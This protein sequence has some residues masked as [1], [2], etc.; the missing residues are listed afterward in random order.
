MK[1]ATRRSVLFLSAAL[2]GMAFIG[3]AVGAPWS[4]FSS[5]T[6]QNSQPALDAMAPAANGNVPVQLAANGVA[7]RDGSYTGPA[8]DAHYGPVQVKANIQNGRLVSVDVLQYPNDRRT[9][10]SIN[11]RAL[12]TLQTEVVRA[13]NTRVNI[14]SGA[15][16]TSSAYLRSLNTALSQAS[17]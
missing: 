8:V 3:S 14:V 16:L 13:Q 10:M 4:L 11:A 5:P 6:A 7:Y 1:F 12:P 2:S 9:S 15:T 17:S